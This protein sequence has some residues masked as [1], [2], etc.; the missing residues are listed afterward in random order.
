MHLLRQ[1]R[2][3]SLHIRHVLEGKG[4]LEE[5]PAVQSAAED[6]VTFQ[7]GV[8]APEYF[9]DFVSRHAEIKHNRSGDDNQESINGFVAPQCRE[10]TRN[11]N[12]SLASLKERRPASA[13]TPAKGS[14]VVSK[15]PS[16]SK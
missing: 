2:A 7:K 6:E 13:V 11:P 8:C 16:T 9:K 10:E 15:F 12:S 1:C 4:A 3:Q 14:L 5:L